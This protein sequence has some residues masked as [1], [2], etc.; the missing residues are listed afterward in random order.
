M[1]LA[2]ILFLLAVGLPLGAAGCGF[3]PMYALS[4]IHI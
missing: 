4:L 2:A 1:R 3:T